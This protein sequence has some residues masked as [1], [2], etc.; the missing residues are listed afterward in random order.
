MIFFDNLYT[1]KRFSAG[2]ISESDG[3]YI[4]ST[5]TELTFDMNIQPLQ[6]YALQSVPEGRR[7]KKNIYGFSDD[8]L[9]TVRKSGN[10][11]INPDQILYEGDYYE[12]YESTLY[13][14]IL[15]VHYEFKA[16]IL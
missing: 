15:G 1:V 9:Y 10:V 7:N 12:V 4:E 5:P 8:K 13:N 16:S 2:T 11:G 3:S 14:N 6:G